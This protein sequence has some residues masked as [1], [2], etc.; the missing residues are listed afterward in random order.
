[1]MELFEQ[2]LEKAKTTT[3]LF[4]KNKLIYNGLNKSQ[5]EMMTSLNACRRTYI[6]NT[7]CTTFLPIDNPAQFLPIDNPAQQKENIITLGAK[8][9]SFATNLNLI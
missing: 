3:P 2:A 8:C 1:M 4:E 6:E 5:H 9:L 7:S